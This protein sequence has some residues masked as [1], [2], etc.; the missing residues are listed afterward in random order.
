[1]ETITWDLIHLCSCQNFVQVPQ[2]G[3]TGR[4]LDPRLQGKTSATSRRTVTSNKAKR[5]L[6][7]NRVSL[8]QV[9]EFF[10]SVQIHLLFTP[11]FSDFIGPLQFRKITFFGHVMFE[12]HLWY[13]DI[14]KKSELLT[15]WHFSAHRAG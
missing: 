6:R 3:G 13:E 12:G 8:G 7:V 11:C 5:Y 10:K 15:F 2:I 14:S 1:M 4:I 9:K